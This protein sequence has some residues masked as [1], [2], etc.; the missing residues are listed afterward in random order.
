VETLFGFP[1]PDDLHE[2]V[3][4]ADRD[5]TG[6]GLD[7]AAGAEEDLRRSG[8]HFYLRGLL[9]VPLRDRPGAFVWGLWV[10]I[11]PPSALRYRHHLDGGA[12]PASSPGVLANRL[13][14]YPETRGLPV[15]LRY[16]P[17]PVRPGI[18]L[19]RVEHPLVRDQLLGLADGCAARLAMAV[20]HGNRRSV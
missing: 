6:R 3:G 14:G 15:T 12:L 20:L 17:G 10:R 11:D 19:D 7:P 1:D 8:V 9:P 16:E 18:E 13:P 2:P 4:P 5:A